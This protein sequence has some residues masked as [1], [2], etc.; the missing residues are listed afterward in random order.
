[1]TRVHERTRTRKNMEV[2]EDIFRKIYNKDRIIEREGEKVIERQRDRER[3]KEG[4]RENERK[5]EGEL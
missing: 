3:K 2:K 4:K 5:K 1:M